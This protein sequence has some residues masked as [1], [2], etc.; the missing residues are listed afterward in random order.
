[1]IKY[2]KIKTKT[3]NRTQALKQKENMKTLRMR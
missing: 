1:M 2:Y 3:K